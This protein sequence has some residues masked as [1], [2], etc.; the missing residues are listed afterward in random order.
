MLQMVV[1]GLLWLVYLL[2]YAWDK[3]K[4][5]NYIVINH[6]LLPLASA[7]VDRWVTLSSICILALT[8]RQVATTLLSLN[9]TRF[10][11]QHDVGGPLGLRLQPQEFQS[12]FEICALRIWHE[13]ELE[14]PR[15]HCNFFLTVHPWI[16]IVHDTWY[17]TTIERPV[18]LCN[19][20]TWCFLFP[21][22]RSL[23]GASYRRIHCLALHVLNLRT[24][25]WLTHFSCCHAHLQYYLIHSI[26]YDN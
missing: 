2:N 24:V 25:R 18:E 5:R 23:P 11:P 3:G 16:S 19:R 26:W 9:V 10:L 1:S 4:L 21:L 15:T 20:T 17:G 6:H 22:L 14:R 12:I 7:H 8:Y 13:L